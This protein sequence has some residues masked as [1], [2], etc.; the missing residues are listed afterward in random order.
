[1][2]CQRLAGAVPRRLALPACR[3][4]GKSRLNF[5]NQYDIAMNQIATEIA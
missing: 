2:L 1:M 4:A 5:G 3:A